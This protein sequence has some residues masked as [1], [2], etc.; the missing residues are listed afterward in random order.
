MFFLLLFA[1]TKFAGP[2]P[3]TVNSINTNKTDS[4]TVTG[5][6][7]VSVPPDVATVNAGIQANAATVKVAQD[8][9]NKVIN[10]ISA[11]EKELGIS[12][13]D[14]QTNN[15]N[16]NPNYDYQNGSQK[17][18]G[19]NANTTLA[20]KVK[21]INKVNSVIDAATANGANQV[22][23]ITFDVNDKTKAENTAREQAVTEAKNKAEQA[24]K[25]AGF[26]LGKIVNYS[27]NFEG[28]PTPIP[29]MAKVNSTDASTP[30]NIEPGS[31]EVKVTVT[32]SY[33]VR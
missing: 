8:Q 29:L 33:E 6:G 19:Y 11:K 24:A 14:I 5:E 12:A 2:I 4:F 9:I 21:D 32:L 7:K 10:Q 17:I 20:I 16:I 15:Y 25:M 18:T 23:N 13:S 31:S 30:T 1:Y 28:G 26:Q 27:E 3:F 22:N